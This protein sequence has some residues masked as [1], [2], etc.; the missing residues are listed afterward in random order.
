MRGFIWYHVNPWPIL[1]MLVTSC[2]AMEVIMGSMPPREASSAECTAAR[3]PQITEHA[4]YGCAM[5]TDHAGQT[6][7]KTMN[8]GADRPD[9]K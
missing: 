9:M 5:R 4:S 8:G 6:I 2:L 7:Y 1:A 3:A